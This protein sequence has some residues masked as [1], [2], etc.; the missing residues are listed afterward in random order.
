MTYNEY[1]QNP[2][3][4]D[5]AVISNRNMYRIMYSEKFDKIL[6]REAGNV[7]YKLYKDGDKYIAYLKIPS[8][9]IDKFYYDVVIEFTPPKGITGATLK[10]YSVRFY[11]ND[12]SFVFTFAHAFIEND[13]FITQY[14]D[15]MSK[16]A[17]K[18]VAKE[19]NPKNQVGY[20]KSLYFA[21][22]YMSSHGL[23]S[24]IRYIDKYNEAAVKR[25]IMHADR[26]IELRQEA[27]RKIEAQ[28][29]KAKV[30]AKK[31]IMDSIH[32]ELPTVMSSAPIRTVKTVGNAVGKTIGKTSSIKRTKSVGKK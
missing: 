5:N 29:K 31:Q 13:M 23:F 11:S 17:V 8:E 7:N 14:K 28:M 20:V 21:Y 16:Q 26:K 6:V 1:I 32:K 30:V 22:L 24:K 3:G 18:K 15:K 4:K 27:Q 10:D 9:L 19:R 25:E 2:M 12:P